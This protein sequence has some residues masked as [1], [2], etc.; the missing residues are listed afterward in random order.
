M[1]ELNVYFVLDILHHFA[2]ADRLYVHP[3]WR[4]Y[5]REEAVILQQAGDATAG[6]PL[7]QWKGERP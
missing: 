3:V 5:L 7:W 4:A 1:D 6:M 2:Q